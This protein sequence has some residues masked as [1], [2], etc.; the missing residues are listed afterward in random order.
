MAMNIHYFYNLDETYGQ[1]L[2]QQVINLD[3]DPVRHMLDP[4]YSDHTVKISRKAK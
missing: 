2:R 1:T 3:Q 4:V